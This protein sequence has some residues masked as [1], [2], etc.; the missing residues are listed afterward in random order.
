MISKYLRTIA[1]FAFFTCLVLPQGLAQSGISLSGTVMD[2]SGAAMPN[3]TVTL[4]KGD[5]TQTVISNGAGGIGIMLLLI[6]IAG[7]IYG[8]VRFIKAQWGG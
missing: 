3:A 2:Q 6:G 1:C 4:R 8:V 5:Q 7:C